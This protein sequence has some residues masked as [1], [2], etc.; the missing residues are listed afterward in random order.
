MTE[1]IYLDNNVVAKPSELAISKMMSLVP[2]H[3]RGT[4]GACK[5]GYDEITEAYK[6]LYDILDA[7]DEDMFIFTSSGVEA[8]NHVVSAV[9]FDIA[10]NSKKNRFVTSHAD[11]MPQIAAMMRLEQLASR[12]RPI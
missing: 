10:C 3:W 11:E 5:E 8:V 6:R 1:N 2:L 12:E 4:R 9:Y 7:D